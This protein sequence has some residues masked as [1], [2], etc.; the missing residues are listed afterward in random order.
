LDKSIESGDTDLVYHVLLHLK[1]KLPLAT[2]FRTINGRPVATALVEASAWD[3]DQ[4]LLK[5]LFYQDD[6]RLDSS[7][8]LLS[9]SLNATD[10]NARNDK[11]KMASKIL[12]ESKDQS[13]QVRAIDEQQK[14]LKFQDTFKRDLDED[15]S[16]LSINETIYKLI[17]LGNV[18]RSQKIQSEFKVSD[19]VY[20]WIRL[21]ALVSRRDWREL[22]DLS[23]TRKSPIG[24]EVCFHFVFFVHTDTNYVSSRS[25]MRFSL[26]VTRSWRLCSFLN[27]R[28]SQ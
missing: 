1:K 19:K 16:G 13:V 2:F 6:R 12:Q 3:Q 18:K 25:S 5:D 22:E 20:W 27:A 21:R 10:A 7:N 15:F 9:D 8:L 11:L 23:K 4:E 24:W 14:L 28:I 17:R 26:L